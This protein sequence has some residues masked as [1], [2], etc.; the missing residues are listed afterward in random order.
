MH[1]E[2]IGQEAALTLPC[3]VDATAL[4]MCFIDELMEVSDGETGDPEG[5]ESSIKEAVEAICGQDRV[6]DT[7]HV[8]ATFDITEAG[9]DVHLT[10]DIHQDNVQHVVAVLDV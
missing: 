6:D 2:L 3:N 9:V 10:C 4:L 1:K 8:I 5:L 7:C